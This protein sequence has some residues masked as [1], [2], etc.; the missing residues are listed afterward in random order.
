L[1]VNAALLNEIIPIAIGQQ[2]SLFNRFNPKTTKRVNAEET[3]GQVSI[4]SATDNDQNIP[5]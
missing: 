1:V 3:V 5:T 2:W 4:T